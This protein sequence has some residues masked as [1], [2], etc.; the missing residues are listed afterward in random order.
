[1]GEEKSAN[2]VQSY[3]VYL[4]WYADFGATDHVTRELDKL[5]I[6]DFYQGGD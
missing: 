1:M 5:A 2:T 6:K 4:N 3:G